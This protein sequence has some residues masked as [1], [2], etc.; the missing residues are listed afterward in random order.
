MRVLLWIL[1][2]LLFCPL[3]LQAQSSADPLAAAG[4][5]IKKGEWERAEELLKVAAEEDS[6]RAEAYYELARLYFDGPLKN[7]ERSKDFAEK[8]LELEPENVA[9]L[10]LRLRQRQEFPSKWFPTFK[11]LARRSLAYKILRLDSTNAIARFELAKQSSNTYLRQRHGISILYAEGDPSNVLSEL[12]DVRRRRQGAIS[13]YLRG[14][15]KFDVDRLKQLGVPMLATSEVAEKEYPEAVRRLKRVLGQAPDFRKAYPA[16]LR[17]YVTKNDFEAAGPVM[18]AMRR[19]F[20]DDA[21]PYLFSGL[22]YFHLDEMQRA[23]QYFDAAFKRMTKDERAAINNPSALLSEKQ[24][25]SYEQA[26]ERFARLYWAGKDIRLL[27]PSNERLLEH[28]ARMA[29]AELFFGKE[30]GGERGWNTARG[31]AYLRYGF[32]EEHYQL[33]SGKD[34][35]IWQYAEYRL[36]FVDHAAGPDERYVL[37][38]PPAGAPPIAQTVNNYAAKADDYPPRSTYAPNSR[39]RIPFLV[40]RFKSEA[41]S[42]TTFY[43]P[44][45]IRTPYKPSGGRYFDWDVD[46]GAF[47]VDAGYGIISQE[48]ARAP[49]LHDERIREFGEATLWHG[50][51]TLSATPGNY[52][53]AVEFATVGD[54]TVG[55]ERI[56]VTA[57]NF[58]G[59]G[60][61]LSDLLLAYHIEKAFGTAA[62]PGRIQRGELSISP[63]AWG[64][65]DAQQPI[66]LY[67][68][69]YNLSLQGGE[70]SYEIQAA[71]AP[72]D[73]DGALEN[74]FESIFGGNEKGGVAVQF[75]SRAST[76]DDGQYLI[77]NAGD[78]PPGEYVLLLRVQDE[79]TG[80]TAEAQ[81]IIVLE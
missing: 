44:F 80:E 1:L 48:R 81:R 26:P 41:G 47:L 2:L 27:T 59:A 45:G 75:A 16:L 33:T 32:P 64:V 63:A 66:Y 31:R 14:R 72:H 39:A 68:E 5:D 78:Q 35:A 38:S 56:E 25:N 15:F 54:E 10:T 53:L 51:H 4:A 22:V 52:E 55:F 79:R 69:V 20:P 17:L 8:A 65:F 73:E 13:Q 60:L 49:R 34:K 9:F 3:T 11:I 46:T 43:V 6:T 12:S 76:S 67:F 57:P 61:M 42:G 23:K 62:A 77:M 30:L 21:N 58:A 18:L 37:Y 7:V 24:K 28:Y 50:V 40:S 71:I 19:Q 70:A 36:V 74:L 29:Y